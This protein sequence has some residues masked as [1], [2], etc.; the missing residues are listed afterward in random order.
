MQPNGEINWPRISVIFN[1][2]TGDAFQTTLRGN[3]YDHGRVS[4]GN[5]N[6]YFAYGKDIAIFNPV[7]RQSR[8]VSVEK[9]ITYQAQFD[10]RDNSLVALIYESSQI[11]LYKVDT[12]NWNFTFLGKPEVRSLYYKVDTHTSQLTFINSR[13]NSRASSV[14]T[15]DYPSLKLLNN[16]TVPS[17]LSAFNGE[18]VGPNQLLMIMYNQQYREY[19]LGIYNTKDSSFKETYK[20]PFQTSFSES[21]F[22]GTNFFVASRTEL[23]TFDKHGKYVKH[24]PYRIGG[25]FNCFIEKF[26]TIEE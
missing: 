2:D 19:T 18:F 15:F 14:V 8:T 23:F 26:G 4:Y 1:T 5:K 9:S 24:V 25:C 16:G 7:T 21:V 22:D 10:S 13:T 6:F 12:T 17:N 3:L 20:F 11:V